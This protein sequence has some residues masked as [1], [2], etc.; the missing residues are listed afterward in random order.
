MYDF[1]TTP[2]Q[3][4]RN[5]LKASWS[6]PYFAFLMDRGT[7]KTKVAIDNA[8]ILFERGEIEALFIIAPNGVHKQWVDEQIPEH[9]PE[10][11]PTIC[12][13]WTGKNTKKAK[14][15]L[16]AFWHSPAKLKIF[17]ANVESFQL[18]G[19]AQTFAIN[20]TRSFKTML[21]IDESTS[22]KNPYAKRSKFLIQKLAPLATYK[23]ILTGNEI[24]RSPFDAYGQYQFLNPFFWTGIPNFHAFQ[25]RY[26]LYKTCSFFKKSVSVKMNCS[27]HKGP[28][29]KL[30][31]KR[32]SGSVFLTCPEC[33]G[34]ENN[35]QKLPKTAANLIQNAGKFEFPQLVKYQNLEDLRERILK[36]SFRAK[37]DECLD[38]PD[39]IYQTI[40][41]EMNAEQKRV[42]E[43]LKN[44]LRTTYK[45]EE[46]TVEIKMLLS[47]R[48][49]QIVG[50]FFPGTDEPI[51]ETNPKLDALIYD[52]SYV[53][54]S[55]PVIIWARF[56]VELQAI[57]KALRA[58]YPNKSTQLY[59]GD[60]D[61][62]KRNEILK[63]F[64]A[65]KVDYF[66]ANP[67]VGGKG[68]NLQLSSLQYNY[69]F[70]N[71]IEDT[72]QAEDRTHRSGQTRKCLY[73]TLF[74]PGTVDDWVKKMN[75]DKTS[76]AEFFRQN[77]N[78]KL[79]EI[80]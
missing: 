21:I 63:D 30:N 36:C 19:I 4:Q 8:G 71:R 6:K 17:S 27:N 62:E 24:T 23:R 68:L 75:A 51:G 39:K 12:R 15:E 26:G 66:V 11:I 28:I 1:K 47:M 5:C 57:G 77:P 22:I 79:D 65:G 78:A 16:G 18:K 42:Y 60:T 56:R 35:N 52:L 50:G 54:E 38:L 7:G 20:F 46:L 55:E 48:F 3:H 70:S 73:K 80:V 34:V 53:E 2:Y 64:K 33:G 44:D 74:M 61:S 10:R 32:L 67:S 25:N 43:E 72:W 45:G 49:L 37:K 13:V 69:S 59:Y 29:D 58:V 31:I 40:N 9:L 14:K 41:C 76:I